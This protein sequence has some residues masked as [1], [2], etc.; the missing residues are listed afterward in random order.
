MKKNVGPVPGIGHRVKSLRNPD[1]RVK[2]LVSYV[3]NETSLRT[4]CLD[5]ALEVEKVTS[6][7]KDNL[8]LNVD[9]TMGAILMDLGFPIHSLNGFFVL[10]R[11]IGMIGHWIDQNEQNSRLIRLYDY[12]INYAV[13]DEREVP[14]KK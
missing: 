12:L 4:P 7:K 5:F 9:G 14:E 13:E 8:I 2:Y 3:K 11:T 1:Q 6:A 10:A